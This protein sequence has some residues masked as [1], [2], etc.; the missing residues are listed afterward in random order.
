MT[1]TAYTPGLKLPEREE[2]RLQFK[3]EL[4]LK[5]KRKLKLKMKE[6]P[7]TPRGEQS[8]L[9]AVSVK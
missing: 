8:L 4:Q 2:K 9:L 1:D 6:M 5:T 3:S 7:P